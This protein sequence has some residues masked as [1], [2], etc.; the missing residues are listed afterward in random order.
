MEWFEGEIDDELSDK[1]YES[2]WSG[3]KYDDDP[4]L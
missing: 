3:Q 1:K 2:I 4:N